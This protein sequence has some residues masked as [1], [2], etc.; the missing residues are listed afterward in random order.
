MLVDHSCEEKLRLRYISILIDAMPLDDGIP[1]F[2]LNQQKSRRAGDLQLPHR[3]LLKARFVSVGRHL[4]FLATVLASSELARAQFIDNF[5]G[6]SVELDPDGIKGWLFRAGDGTATM[7]FRQ[8][9][10]GY[11]SMFVDATT[12]KRGI[13]WALIERKASEH[14]DLS[15]MQKPGHEFRIE[16]RIRVSHAP[17]RVN[18]QVATQRS[19][20]YDANLMEYDIADTNNWHVISM[21]TRNFD[22]RPGDTV[23]AHMAMMDWGLEK[24]RVD[25]DY[26]KMDLVDAATVGPDLGDPIPYHPPVANPEKFSQHVAVEQDSMIDLV[27]TDINENDWSVQDR[28]RGKINLLT[29]DETHDVILRWD[30][31]RFAG[32]KVADHGLL[33]LTT[34]S[35]QRKAEYVKDFGLIRVV[36][37]LGGDPAWEQKTVT[38]DSF[39]HYK[40]LNRVLNTQMIID[41]PVAPEEGS[42]TYLTISRTVLQRMIDGKTLGIAIKALGAL[43]ASF[44]SMED[45]QG[46]YSA[47]LH[48][49]LE[50]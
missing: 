7:D 28:S 14:M 45:E 9:G 17:R 50:K 15:L 48:F 33:E 46:K 19:T 49:N 43:D 23:F 29:V 35:S 24:Y 3:F 41:W 6:P 4:L 10:R 21:I 5:N 38:T 36:E 22:A 18:L 1:I 47:R 25:V 32:K 37:I 16:A 26:I 40:Q 13:W 20:D 39:C 34:Y 27:D 30:L 42:K 11:A 8:G 31:S 44:Y 12:D 2:M